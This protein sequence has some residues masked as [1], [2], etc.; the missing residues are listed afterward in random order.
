VLDR[1]GARSSSWLEHFVGSG[2]GAVVPFSREMADAASAAFDQFSRTS[3]PLRTA[4]GP[5]L[6]DNQWRG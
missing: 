3:D 1:S 6:R 5:N 4:E 2:R